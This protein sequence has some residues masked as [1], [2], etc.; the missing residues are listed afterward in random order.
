MKIL[1]HIGGIYCLTFAIFH[2]AFW[3]L[4]DWKNDLP[5]L[6]SVNRGVIQVLNL[7]LTY[8]F[9]VVAF[10]SFF[11]ADDLINTKLGNVILASISIFAFMRAI[12]QLIFWKI[13]KIGIAFFFIF[14]IGAGIFAVP[15]FAK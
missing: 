5:K 12:E 2:L 7:R 3:K 11:F 15:L 14:L 8:V 10:I 13:E 4:F 1:I 6:K 9:I